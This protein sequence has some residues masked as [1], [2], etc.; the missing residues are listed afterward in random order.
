M[1]GLCFVLQDFVSFLVLQSSRLGRERNGYF[2]CVL[3]AMSLL[4]FLDS[5]SRCHGL[6]CSM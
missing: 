5:S 3:N 6:A 4:S 1:L 2:C